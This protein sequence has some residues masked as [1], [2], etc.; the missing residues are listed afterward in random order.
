MSRPGPVPHRTSAVGGRARSSC[1]TTAGRRVAPLPGGGGCVMRAAA[2]A[3]HRV[4][5]VAKPAIRLEQAGV[6]RGCALGSAARPCEPRAARPTPSFR[7]V[8]KARFY[9]LHSILGPSDG[10]LQ[11]TCRGSLTW[12][13]GHQRLPGRR[14]AMDTDS[15]ASG[16]NP[17]PCLPTVDTQFR[18]RGK[19]R[20]LVWGT[21]R[22]S[23]SPTIVKSI[24]LALSGNGGTLPPFDR[25]VEC[26][27]KMQASWGGGLPCSGLT[28]CRH[29]ESVI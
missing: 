3:V 24:F 8:S 28:Q 1:Q 10:P 14:S 5:L 2:L 4:S 20:A 23:S 17:R 13:S 22:T 7:G 27:Q 26:V 25:L 29:G 11:L 12:P 16:P 9:S 6:G 18:R 15:R 19:C 21:C